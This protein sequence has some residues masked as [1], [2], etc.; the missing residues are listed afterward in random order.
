[1]S[2]RQALLQLYGG[3]ASEAT[4]ETRGRLLE[5]FMVEPLGRIRVDP[6]GE[7]G[8]LGQFAES[9]Q[10]LVE[11]PAPEERGVLAIEKLE[12]LI[13]TTRVLHQQ[14]S[15]LREE[16][17]RSDELAALVTAVAGPEADEN[18][19]QALI[20]YL[21]DIVPRHRPSHIWRPHAA[22]EPETTAVEAVVEAFRAK[23]I[24]LHPDIAT[25]P[26]V[27]CYASIVGVDLHGEAE[28]A[29]FLETLTTY[30]RSL[31]AFSKLKLKDFTRRLLDPEEW[32]HCH[33]FWCAMT[34]V[35]ANR[36]A[37]LTQQTLDALRGQCQGKGWN[38]GRIIWEQVGIRT[39]AL[40]VAQDYWSAQAG[41][42]PVSNDW[43]P[44]TLLCFH[45]HSPRRTLLPL[46]KRLRHERLSYQILS[47]GLPRPALGVDDGVIDVVEDRTANT[48]EVH[49]TKTLYMNQRVH[50]S[51]GQAIA[52]FACQSGWV[53]QTRSLIHHCVFGSN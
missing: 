5:R 28:F 10:T 6:D 7:V 46:R 52:E 17:A 1:M 49:I 42:D 21:D 14:G 16:V 27:R 15:T 8:V 29:V 36:P 48:I 53:T 38:P 30:D 3:L 47:D 22:P 4:H 44:R 32:V 23:K 24:E 26:P 20:E 31:P 13:E 25:Q 50:Q 12:F 40:P 33:D 34:D 41:E 37:G 45:R 43:F 2:Q 19:T 18:A 39:P 9:V 51:E 11:E 35:V